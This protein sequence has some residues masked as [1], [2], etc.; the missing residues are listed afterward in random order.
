M[1]SSTAGLG[2]SVT[3]HL[4]VLIFQ[5]R[6][7]P[8]SAMEVA[9]PYADA[10]GNPYNVRLISSEPLAPENRTLLGE[11]AQAIWFSKGRAFEDALLAWTGKT[12]FAV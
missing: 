9:V 6:E 4:P 7:T 3:R 8:P 5:S 12:L 1:G 2:N 10:S 11:F